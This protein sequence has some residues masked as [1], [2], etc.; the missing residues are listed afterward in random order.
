VGR[1][2][3]EAAVRQAETLDQREGLAVLGVLAAAAGERL[4]EGMQMAVRVRLEL[5]LLRSTHNESTCH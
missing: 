4:V 3:L 5:L 1:L 2:I